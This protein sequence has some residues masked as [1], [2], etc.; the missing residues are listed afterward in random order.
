MALVALW[1]G[2]SIPSYFRSVSPLVLEAAAQ[3][4]PT[5][6][7][8]ALDQVQS[9][10]PGLA[11]RLLGVPGASTDPARAA[12][13]STAAA[14]LVASQPA[15]RWSGGPA[16]FYEQ[17]LRQAPFLREDETTVLP[18]LLPGEHRRELLGFLQ[19]S[20]NRNVHD[21]LSTRELGGWQRF[22]PVYSNSGQPLDAT[23]L[24]AA[25][26]EQA[27]ALPDG[28]RQPLLEAARQAV[29]GE[30]AALGDL[31]TIY[32]GILTLG[33]HLDWLSLKTMIGKLDSTQQLL[34]TA[35]SIQEDPARANILL[36][37]YLNVDSVENLTGFLQRHGDRGWE[38][39]L[40]AL[41]MGK[42][43]VEAVLAF[44]KPVY[45]PPMLWQALPAFVRHS[46]QHFKGFAE[47]Q[48]R[49]ALIGRL[50]AFGMCGFC[51][52]GILRTI[53]LGLRPAQSH[54]RRVLV[55]LDSL[56]GAVL[57]TILVWVMIEP[58]LLDFRP[59]EQGT[60]EIK[61][62][63]IIPEDT[64]STNETEP[65]PMIDQ[66]TIL[67]LLL[68]FIIQMLVFIMCLLKIAEIRRQA[69]TPDVKLKLL[70]NEENLFDLG[71]Y[72][73]L[74]GTVASLILVVLNIVD[75]SLMAAYASTLFG[76]IFVATLK[77]GYLRP[78]RRRLILQKS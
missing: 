38:A 65:I 32:I 26:L 11:V 6:L 72:V 45:Q 67:V 1:L 44:D 43:A 66:V 48:P 21:L 71:L 37:A 62:A 28:L 42:G 70:E 64:L 27:S 49:A 77:I 30:A 33:R 35:Q 60:L 22:Y 41:G 25:L 74:G 46:Q 29:Q 69:F 58:G 54:E 50:L 78:F 68:F 15:Y 20:P 51:L 16:P 3:G 19:Q 53:V 10:R 63:Q 4:T 75:A 57:V 13:V 55:N 56:V 39:L 14:A 18:T 7:A 24:T 12:E 40:T 17:F 31:E 36:A 34:F 9:G 8:Q 52:V 73:G 61:L 59:N 76:I 23:I 5:L 47:S 2:M